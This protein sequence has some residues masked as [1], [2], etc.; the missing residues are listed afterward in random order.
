MKIAR[1]FPRKTTATPDDLLAYVDKP[2]RNI[3]DIDEVH[4]S[5]TFTYDI[6]IAE[7]IER[8]WRRFGIPVKLG[9]PAYG[10]SGGDFVPGMYL[11]HGY[12]ITS[13]GCNNKCWFCNVWRREGSL[14]ELPITDGWNVLDDNF[15]AC[16]EAHI[17]S[18]FDMLSRQPQAP[19]FTG[20][21]E[22]RLLKPWHVELF[23]AAGTKRMYF[24][25]DVPDDYEPLV[26]AGKT[27][28]AGRFTT[29]SH[30]AACYVLIG[31]RGDTF[32]R[33]EKRLIQTIDAGFFPYAM[34]YRDQSG[35]VTKEWSSFHREWCRPQIVGVKVKERHKEVRHE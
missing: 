9:G 13:R 17:R 31:Y 26:E 6:P 3:P 19:L 24:A 22:A 27:L 29:A 11:K 21:L 16:S 12:V 4:I 25:Y 20:G 34:L 5:V 14:H 23:K 2:P 18:V 7:K 28:R 15:L 10:V 30:I 35:E 8:E 33:A 32:E 1:V